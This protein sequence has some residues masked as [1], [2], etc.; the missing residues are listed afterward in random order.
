MFDMMVDVFMNNYL[1]KYCSTM[2][3]VYKY[4]STT[5]DVP[6]I[7]VVRHFNEMYEWIIDFNANNMLVLAVH[8]YVFYQKTLNV[9]I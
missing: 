9:N 5:V 6:I 4:C 1:H 2:A 3:D 7:I 8:N